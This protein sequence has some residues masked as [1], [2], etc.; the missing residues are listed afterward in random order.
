MESLINLGGISLINLGGIW[1]E[2]LIK[3]DA[4]TD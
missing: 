3:L 1:V 4:I 2:S